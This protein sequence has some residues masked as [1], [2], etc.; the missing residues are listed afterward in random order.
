MASPF[1]GLS[2]A[3]VSE[4]RKLVPGVRIGSLVKLADKSWPQGPYIRMGP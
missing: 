2:E 3:E 1:T 4:W